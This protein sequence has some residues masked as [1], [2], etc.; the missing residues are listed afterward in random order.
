VGSW[1]GSPVNF[2]STSLTARV[3]KETLEERARSAAQLCRRIETLK[4]AR[5]VGVK[6]RSAKSAIMEQQQKERRREFARCPSPRTAARGNQREFTMP[7][8]GHADVNWFVRAARVV[9]VIAGAA[10]VGGLIGGFAMF[11]AAV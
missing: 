6:F 9:P 2:C 3:G 8:G 5:R 11:A 7:R 10:L 1:L 4:L